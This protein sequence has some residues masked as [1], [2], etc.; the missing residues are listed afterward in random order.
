VQAIDIF[1]TKLI[2]PQNQLIIIPNGVVSNNSINNFTQLGTRR[3]ALDIG[4][5]YDAD[6]RQTK[7]ILM[8]VI[9]NNQ[10][11]L[12]DPAPQVV[13]TELGDSAVNVSVR[14]STSTENF[15]KMNEELI[16]G[17]KALDKAG[18]GIPFPQRDVHVYNQQ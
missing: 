18:I 3:T 10:Y 17:C 2:T 14:V 12:K 13:V 1:H 16:I 9:K 4:I 6:L 8:E 11:A 15:W 5:A 7:D